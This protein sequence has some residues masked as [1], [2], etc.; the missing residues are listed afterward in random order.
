MNNRLSAI[1]ALQKVRD[2][3]DGQYA[4]LLENGTMELGFY[5]PGSVDRQQPHEQDEVYI[6]QAGHGRFERGDE[7]IDF[8]AGDAIFVAAGVQHRF[9]DFSEDFATWVVFYGPTGGE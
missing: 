6:V 7:V 1:R 5:K 2:S 3:A 4:V 8:E 9:V